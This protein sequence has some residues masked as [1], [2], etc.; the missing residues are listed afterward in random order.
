MKAAT[1]AL[2]FVSAR[3]PR[4]RGSIPW[5]WVPLLL[6]AS[7]SVFAVPSEAAKPAA[8][9][10]RK[11]ESLAGLPPQVQAPLGVGRHGFMGIADRGQDFNSTDMLSGDMPSRRLR[12]ACM[13]GGQVIV[14]LD[15]GG[16]AMH[17]ELKTF[18][19]KNG[20]W[21][22]DHSVVLW[23]GQLSASDRALLH[24]VDSFWE[25]GQA[26]LPMGP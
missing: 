3:W 22:E 23:G 26:G 14:V 8:S 6:A 15:L 11:V 13:G 21:S 7:G 18:A 1:V 4:E 16:I 2:R 24:T 20:T 17:G 25:R 5:L 12:R 9:V 19:K 10:C